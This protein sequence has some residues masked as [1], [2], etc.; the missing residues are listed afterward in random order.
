[1][2]SRSLDDLSE[3]MR[4]LTLDF[5]AACALEKIDVLIYC[6]LRSNVEQ[7]ALYAQG[8][9][10]PG[11]IVTNAKAGQSSHNPG[12]DGKARAF[13]AVPLLHGKPQWNDAALYQRLGEIA[14]SVGLKWAGRW[15][16]RLREVAHF[17]EDGK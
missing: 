5:L 16:G 17:S 9:T 6:T 13:D 8:R 7:D 12:K 11:H 10:T 3:H 2:A 14:E 15:T 4:R 1:M